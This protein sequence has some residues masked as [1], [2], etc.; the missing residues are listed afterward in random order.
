MGVFQ[1]QLPDNLKAVMDRQISEGRA[2]SEASYVEEAIRR[3]AEE[4]DAEDEIVA[5]AQA[6]IADIEAGRYVTIATL[7]DRRLLHERTMARLRAHLDSGK[8]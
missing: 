7:E 3:Y 5:I 2:E 1:V 6:G 4:L 8:S